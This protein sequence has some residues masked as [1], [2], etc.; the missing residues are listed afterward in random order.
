MYRYRRSYLKF[1]SYYTCVS[2]GGQS[3]RLSSALFGLSTLINYSNLSSNYIILYIYIYIYIY[4]IYLYILSVSTWIQLNKT[5][6]IE[7]SATI[8]YTF[9]SC[10][11]KK[12]H[13]QTHQVELIK[14]FLV[15]GVFYGILT[16]RSDTKITIP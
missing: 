5:V 4:N 11:D 9:Y 10:N 13:K 12:K 7:N 14:A 8:N 15:T 16:A 1:S 2:S 3:C 6:S